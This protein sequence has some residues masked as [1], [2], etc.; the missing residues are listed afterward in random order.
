MDA[1]QYAKDIISFDTTSSLSNVALTDYLEDR[2]KQMGCRTERLEYED[3]NGVRKASVVGKKGEGRGGMAY[4]GHTDVVPAINWFTEDHGPFT[5]AVRQGK[6]YGRGACDMKGSVASMLAAAER[7]EAGELNQ[8][9]YIACTADEEIGYGGAIQVKEESLFYREM[10][11]AQTRTIVGEPT[12]LDVVYAH[13]GGCSFE[14]TARG[15][16][17]HSS[18]RVGLNANWVMIPFLVRMKELY[19]E[20]Q[21]SPEWQDAEFDPPTLGGNIGIEDY[22]EAMNVKKPISICRIGFRPM[23]STSTDRLIER[24]TRA[25]QDCGVELK[26]DRGHEAFH[27]DPTSSFVREVVKVTGRESARTVGYGSEASVYTDLKNRVLI[28][29][30]DVEQAH[31]FDEWISVEQL[32]R[33]ADTYAEFIRAWCC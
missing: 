6:L 24:V 10:V 12:L 27:V 15:E 17:A 1:L 29:P 7:F 18:T 20:T 2:L 19:D 11:E 4:F 26:V 32:H 8:P 3:E 31:T 28:G 21:S 23:P 14:A 5:P 9:V 30:G 25:A 13:K 22:P 16:S 33:G